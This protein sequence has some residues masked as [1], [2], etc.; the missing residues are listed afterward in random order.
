MPSSVAAL[1]PLIT[2]T[3]AGCQVS[4]V[5]PPE[6]LDDE[7]RARLVQQLRAEYTRQG[8]K[9]VHG[10]PTPDQVTALT[11]AAEV[12]LGRIDIRPRRRGLFS[13]GEGFVVR[14]H[15][16]V[17][18]KPPPDGRSER[19]YLMRYRVPGGWRYV[20]ELRGVELGR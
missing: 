7:A 16:T 20:R 6:G 13:R 11:D 9:G 15:P 5:V 18:G 2:L 4:G 3:L 8:L 12:D 10:T 14:V 19:A 1:L 17:N